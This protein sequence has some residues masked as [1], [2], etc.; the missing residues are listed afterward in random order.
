MVSYLVYAMLGL[1]PGLHAYIL[2][3]AFAAPISLQT[4]LSS[5]AGTGLPGLT[6][7]V[8]II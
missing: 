8:L 3:L 4:C 5:K 1:E 6:D 2:A 7:S